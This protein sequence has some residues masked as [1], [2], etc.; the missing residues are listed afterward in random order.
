MSANE[1]SLRTNSEKQ[2]YVLRVFEKEIG[3]RLEELG[4]RCKVHHGCCWF[5]GQSTPRSS[6]LPVRH[7]VVIARPFLHA[8][9]TSTLVQ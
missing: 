2:T 8:D 7:C 1:P 3:R 5:W 4:P 6:E 9:N